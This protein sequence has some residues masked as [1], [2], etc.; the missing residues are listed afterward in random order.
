MFE[1]AGFFALGL[2]VGFSGALAPGP[3]LVATIG[4]SVRSGWLA[5]PKVV[6]GHLVVELG[7]ILVIAFGI[8]TGSLPSGGLIHLIGGAAL[9]AFGILTLRESRNARLEGA[10]GPD[11]S[12]Y[13]AGFLTTIAN[14][15]FW[16]WWFSIGAALFISGISAGLPGAVCFIL[17]HWSADLSWYTLVSGAVHRGRAFLEPARYRTLLTV[18]GLFLVLF[19]VS[20]IFG[21]FQ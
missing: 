11:G 13:V 4:E 15:Y 8:G 1:E 5:G 17:G 12:P 2:A 3:M 19:G 20:Y 18:C 14:P 7:L 16:I 10:G 6:A 9:I 21:I